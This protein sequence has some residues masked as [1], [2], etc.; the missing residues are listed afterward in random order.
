MFST[1]RQQLIA[2][3]VIDCCKNG[4][5]V[6]GGEILPASRPAGVRAYFFSA[7]RVITVR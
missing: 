4:R 5:L 6:T 1:F 7:W 3:S 2:R